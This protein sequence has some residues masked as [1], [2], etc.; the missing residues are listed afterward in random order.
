MCHRSGFGVESI[1]TLIASFAAMLFLVSPCCAEQVRIGLTRCKNV[2]A[3]T[4]GATGDY[5]VAAPDGKTLFTAERLDRV[6]VELGEKGLK[7]MSPTGAWS[8]VGQSVWFEPAS[9]NSRLFFASISSKLAQYRGR[10]EIRREEQDLMPINDLDIEDYLLGVVALEMPAKFHPEAL[11]AQAVAARTYTIANA[12]KHS[13]SGYGLCDSRCC[14]IYWGA[15]WEKESTSEAV[16]AT[17][18]MI[19]TYKGRPIEAFYSADCGGY[20][21]CSI[22]SNGRTIPYLQSRPDR[23]GDGHPDFCAASPIHTW[24]KIYS[25]PELERLL[26]EAGIVAS[27]IKAVRVSST[28]PSGRAADV[29]IACAEGR[30]TISAENLR[31][32]L[33]LKEINSTLFTIKADPEGSFTFDGKG[34]GHGAGLCQY[35]ANGMASPPYNHTFEQ[36]L[37]HYYPGAQLKSTSPR[38][39]KPAEPRKPQSEEKE[40]S[41]P[42]TV[43]DT[44]KPPRKAPKGGTWPWSF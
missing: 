20:T 40:K 35:G 32:A 2:S 42:I 6:T 28:T 4:I 3:I 24:T 27:R 41:P 16:R 15:E 30:V 22:N 36:I 13:K 33:G 5:R 23:A 31:R 8:D 7:L 26:K 39:L 43:E 14:Q 25:A 19:L 44:P 18:G 37:A 9:S 29:E 10:I 1:L 17:Q 38:P 12:V 34:W 11:K 21:A